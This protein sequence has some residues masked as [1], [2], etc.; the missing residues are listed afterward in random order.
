LAPTVRKPVGR[1]PSGRIVTPLGDTAMALDT[2]GGQGANNG[3]KMARNLVESIIA[4]GDQPFDAEWMTETFERFYARFGGITNI[5]N[6]LLLE[7][8]TTA[9]KQLLI[10]QYGSDGR[11]RGS[12][13]QQR[14]ADAFI[15]NFNDAN[16]LTGALLDTGKARAVIKEKTGN[17][18]PLAVTRG[19]LGVAKGQFRQKLGRDP[20]HPAVH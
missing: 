17:S 7:P 19:A 16:V 15:E 11:A 14:I 9:G 6:N 1:L 12:S 18:W 8:I 2:V 4:R 5:F 10:A 20:G 3:N 13:G